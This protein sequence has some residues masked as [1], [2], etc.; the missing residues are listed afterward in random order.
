MEIIDEGAE[1]NRIEEVKGWGNTSED[2]TMVGNNSPKR[3]ALHCYT[4]VCT[5]TLPVEGLGLSSPAGN[6]QEF[7]VII[8]ITTPCTVLALE[9]LPLLYSHPTLS[10]EI[11]FTIGGHE[12]F[13]GKKKKKKREKSPH[14]SKRYPVEPQPRPFPRQCKS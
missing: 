2:F 7:M 4:Y 11:I 12:L 9:C 6:S 8:E 1:K 10:K 13:C 14:H 3:P 5:I